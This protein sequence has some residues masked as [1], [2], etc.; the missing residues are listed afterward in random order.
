MDKVKCPTCQKPAYRRGRTKA[1]SQRWRC[2]RC[3]RTFTPGRKKPGRP[4]AGQQSTQSLKE[5]YI[6]AMMAYHGAVGIEELIER[7]AAEFEKEADS[8]ENWV[9]RDAQLALE[10][11]ID[12]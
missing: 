3:D 1:G 10:K 5:G 8:D 9:S 6:K 7:T 11:L 2:S 12:K 4:S